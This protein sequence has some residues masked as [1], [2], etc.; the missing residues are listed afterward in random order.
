MHSPRTLSILFICFLHEDLIRATTT[1]ESLLKFEDMVHRI[2][3][4]STYRRCG[5]DLDKSILKSCLDLCELEGY[6]CGA[7]FDEDGNL[8]KQEAKGVL[9]SFIYI[10]YYRTTY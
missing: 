3:P 10:F 6:C 1:D 9:S 5:T 2:H 8:G 4:T 7:T